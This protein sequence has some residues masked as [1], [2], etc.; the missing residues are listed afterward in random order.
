[1]PVYFRCKICEEQHPAPVPCDD[2]R[3]FDS[4]SLMTISFQCPKTQKLAIYDK[5]DMF[6]KDEEES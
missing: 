6:W 1:M 3:S 2:E 4:S 5:E